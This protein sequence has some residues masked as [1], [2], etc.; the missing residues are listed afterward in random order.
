LLVTWGLIAGSLG[1]VVI[2]PWALIPALF[3]IGGRQLAL[4]ILMHEAAHRTLFRSRWLNDWVG[5]GLAAYF[6]F[7]SVEIYRPIHYAHHAHAGTERDPDRALA[8]GYPAGPASMR[9][10]ILRDLSGVVGVRRAVATARFLWSA[11]RHGGRTQ[12]T[13]VEPAVARRALV[14]FL[15]AQGALVAGLTALGHPELYLVWAVAWLTTFSLAMRLRSIAE[16]AMMEEGRDP[17]LNTRTV[18]ARWWERWLVAPHRVNYHLEHHLM[19]TVPHHQL[20]RFHRL[21]RDRGQLAEAT[22]V[23]GYP[24]VWRQAATEPRL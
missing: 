3:V 13:W 22:V 8:A 15:A 21:L 11:A 12:G 20:P 5:D 1:S 18:E 17:I 16:H 24:R 7:L 4:A 19:M 6:V 2:T 9:R 14:G 23:R 10:K